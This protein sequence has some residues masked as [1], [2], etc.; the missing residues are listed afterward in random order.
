M[1]A[2]A[3]M[4]NFSWLNDALQQLFLARKCMAYRCAAGGAARG[5]T[6]CGGPMLL[7][8]RRLRPAPALRAGHACAS[9]CPT[10]CHSYIFAFYM[11]GQSMF[12]EDFTPEVRGG[13]RGCCWGRRRELCVP[14]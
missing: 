8:C 3:T 4:S 6:G 2:D 9:T 11:F 10:F 13:F 12:R 1:E 7:G 14:S 5:G